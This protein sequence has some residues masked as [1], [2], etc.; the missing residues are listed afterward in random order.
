MSSHPIFTYQT[1]PVLDAGQALVLDAYAKLYGY[2]ERSLFA[3][4]QTGKTLNELKREFL[5]K[6]EITARQ[7]NAIR[8]G[9]DG[10]VDAIKQRRPELITEA[11]SKIKKALKTVAKLEQKAPGSNK[12]HQKKRRL[13]TLQARLAAM[14]AD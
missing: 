3:A 13:A 2:V 7:F 10:K 5:P 9:L 8:V 14:Q 12:L 1:R 11:Q 4:M 6:F